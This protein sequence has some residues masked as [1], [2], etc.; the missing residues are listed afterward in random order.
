MEKTIAA[1]ATGNA[2]GGIGVIRIS[3]AHAIEI[4]DAVFCSADKSPLSSLPGYTARFGSVRKDGAAFDE[5]VAL[6]FRAPKSYTG[7]D[8]VELSVHG[9][10]VVV[11]KTLEAVLDAGAVSAQP[12]E[13][14]KRAFL[15]GKMDLT[16]A[17]S[18]AAIISASGETAA[19][20]AYTALSG[21]LYEKI[22]EILEALTDCSALMAA[23]VDYPDEE[24]PE[25]SGD[26]LINTLSNV[27]QALDA[28]LS[29]YASGQIMTCGVDTAI[30]GRPNVG[31]SSLMNLLS[32]QEKSIVTDIQGTTRDIVESTV[33]LG[34]LVLHLSDTAGLRESAD[35]VESIGIQRAVEKIEQ[36]ELVLAVFDSSAE[37]TPEDARLMTLCQNKR[38]VAVM[39]KQDLPRQAKLRQIQENFSQVVF[40]SAKE[41][42]GK[43]E[44]E[45]A[46]RE[47]LGVTNFDAGAPILANG[48]QKQC[49]KEA[50]ARVDEALYAAQAGLTFDA[51]NVMI[52]AAIDALLSLTGRKATEEVVNN[53]FSKFCVG[54]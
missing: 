10:I 14:T 9:G 41:K 32:G 48:R 42:T 18:V 3:G 28:L 6:V 29:D 27:H 5:A 51:I 22:S 40:L 17:E 54:K 8:V 12:G 46:V 45:A 37:L 38:A 52:D 1:V 21:A 39:N 20:S 7:E 35:Q 2:A 26:R 4:A 15:N 30:V 43:Q 47:L 53:I 44:L 50:L 31:K 23:W 24:I 13:F 25:L 16:K 11:E 34:S 19:K 33:R 36:A 49:C